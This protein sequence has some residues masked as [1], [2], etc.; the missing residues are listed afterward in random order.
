M[1]TWAPV[2][3]AAKDANGNFQVQVGGQWR[4]ARK[5]AKNADGQFVAMMDDVAPAQEKPSAPEYLSPAYMRQKTR[6]ELG[7]LV[8]GAGSI[9]ATLMTPYDYLVG[10]TQSLGNPERRAAMDNAL[11]E[12]GANPES[13][14]YGASKFVSEMAGT[15]GIPVAT[16]GGVMLQTGKNALAGAAGAGLVNPEDAATGAIIGGAAAPVLGGVKWA[17]EK[18]MNKIVNPLLDLVRKSGAKNVLARYIREVVGEANIPATINA[19]EQAVIP[20]QGPGIYEVPNYPATVAETMVGVPEGSP[21]AALQDL[22]ARTK[23][24]PSATFGRVKVRQDNALDVAERANESLAAPLRN[25]AL[26][27]AN[28]AGNELPRLMA[29]IEQRYAGRNLARQAEGKLSTLATQ[30]ENLANQWSEGGIRAHRAAQ[31]WQLPTSATPGG[32]TN[33]ATR[34]LSQVNAPVAL[35]PAGPIPGIPAIP[36]RYAPPMQNVAP[37]REGAEYASGVA[38]QRTQEAAFKKYQADSLAAHGYYPLTPDSIVSSIDKLLNKS[39][40]KSNS[41]VQQAL[42]EIRDTLLTKATNKYGYVDANELYTIR[43]LEAGNVIEKFAK[44]NASWDK[45]MTAGLLSDVKAAIDDAIEK[46][47]GTGW[48]DY[49]RDYSGR[50]AAIE[51]MRERAALQYTP[52]QQTNLGGGLSIAEQTREHIPNLLSRTAMAGNFVLRRLGNKLEPQID[53]LA[54]EIFTNPRK[55]AEFMKSIPQ[56]YRFKVDN[57]LRAAQGAAVYQAE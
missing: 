22:T 43:K 17:A 18:G 13:K 47:G 44:E 4:P 46:S 49:L 53:D 54:A 8:R 38:A 26:N 20:K 23:G 1:S 55:Y 19:A 27:N 51:G 50:K 6:D 11:R 52:L 28:T 29:D 42:G 57:A 30:Q 3:K 35:P 34:P 25:A 9:G 33:N 7:G 24:G 5:V 14:S 41:T 12:L 15:A 16:T 40:N 31:S 39:G 37:A 32:L 48:K 56:E 10:N 2:D 21:L 45:K 36:G